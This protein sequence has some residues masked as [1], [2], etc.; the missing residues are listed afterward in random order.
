[1]KRLGVAVLLLLTRQA[2]ATNGYLLEGYG[3]D[4]K[5]TELPDRFRITG[6]LVAGSALFGL[7]WGLSGICPGPGL[8]LLT[9]DSVQSIVFVGAIIAGFFGGGLVSGTE[10]PGR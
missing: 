6:R 9:G 10:S 3:T 1:M 2:V 4:S 7:G 5:V 8:L